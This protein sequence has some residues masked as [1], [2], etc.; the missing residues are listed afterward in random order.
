[1]IAA[2]WSWALL[3]GWLS[4]LLFLRTYRIWLPYYVLGSV[5]LAYWMVLAGRAWFGLDRWMAVLVAVTTQRLAD[6]LAIPTQTFAQAPGTLLVMVISQ[7]IGW[8]ALQVG[9]E[10]SGLLE[11]SVLTALLA[12][13]PG[14]S[15]RE[16]G[17]LILGC[18]VLLIA[19][20]IL[21]VLIIVALLHYLGKEALL[22]AH[23]I[24]GKVV[25]FGL[26]LA[27]YWLAI[28]APTLRQLGRRFRQAR[29]L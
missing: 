18:A 27:I 17:V 6:L 1:M 22:L 13:Y 9:V 12:L 24:I 2:G 20:N 23:T 19:A 25:F 28:T 21:R 29:A 11:L 4:V 26:T 10:S 5:G 14:W 8:T 16:R 3:L 7:E 15:W